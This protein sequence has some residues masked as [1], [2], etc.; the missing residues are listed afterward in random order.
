M[1]EGPK[2]PRKQKDPQRVCNTVIC[3]LYGI[4]YIYIC[5][6]YRVYKHKDPNMVYSI[7]S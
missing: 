6:E 2:R 4:W 1:V 7:R 5:I 3:R